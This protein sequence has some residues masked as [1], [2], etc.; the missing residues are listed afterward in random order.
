VILLFDPEDRVV[1]ANDRAATAYGYDLQDLLRLS[2]RDIV[3]RSH[4]PELPERV[5]RTMEQGSHLFESV[6]CRSDGSQLPVE[7]SSRAVEVDGRTFRQCVVRDISERK[8]AEQELRRAIRAMRVLS[9]SNQALV[10]SLDEDALFQAICEAAT[11]VGGYSLALIGLVEH[12]EN[13]SIRIAASAGQ[14]TA[15]LDSFQVTWG[16]RPDGLGPTGSCVRSGKIV[17]CNDAATDPAFQPWRESAAYCGYKSLIALPLQCDGTVIGT[18]TIYASEPDAF[19]SEEVALLNELAGDLSYGIEGHR[20]RADQ[21]RAEEALRQAVTEFRTLFNSANDAIFIVDMK[22][23]ILEANQVACGRLGYRR[24]E[25]TRLTVH[26]VDSPAFRDQQ[27]ARLTELVEY[28]QSLFES[29]HVRKDGKELP[30][31]ISSCLFEYRAGL[32]ILAVARDISDR[33]QAEAA[34]RRQARELERAKVEAEKASY[35]KSEFLANMSHEIRTP[36]NGILGMSALL[37]DTALSVEQR[38]N[39]EVIQRSTS[40]LLRI[41]N[42]VLDLSKIEAGKMELEPVCFDIVACVRE[43]GELLAP[44]AQAKGLA[45]VFDAHAPDCWVRGDAGRLR[46]I[47][48]N[49]L[50]NA[51]KFTDSGEVRLKL[52]GSPPACGQVSFSVSVADTGVGIRA[53]DLARLFEA[54][55]QVDSSMSKRHQGTGLGLTISRRLADMMNASLTVSSEPGKGTTFLL[56]VRLPLV[57]PE[58]LSGSDASASLAA[59]TAN[60]ACDRRRVLLAEDNAVNKKIGVRL[61][62]KCGC[63]VDVAD[64]G[65]QAVEMSGAVAYDAIFMDCGMPEMD[66]YEATRQ[67]RAREQDRCRTPIIA[68]TAHAVA[69]TREECL[70]AGMD[71]YITKPVSPDRL[72]QALRKWCPC[73][74]DPVASS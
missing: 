61:L 33:K 12:D 7:V 52:T 36:M 37:L 62:E 23:H 24:E 66:G 16:E 53:E 19:G 74:D 39:V 34:A 55:T 67:I 11:V 49:L 27:H 43:V 14:S 71:D 42:D 72:E 59:L 38:E 31:E 26:D 2:V 69:G 65:A 48:L 68:L 25:L 58:H 6:H 18:L 44:Q 5:R 64:N 45:F 3:D 54:F 41:V 46:Q 8:R 63:S 20:R 40:A 50:S 70:R 28:G 51:I 1:Q 29:V 9:A 57:N 10:R 22:G 15:Y 13:K 73:A 30:V 17:I 60:L 32:S 47:V 4:W 21:A 35:A 56:I